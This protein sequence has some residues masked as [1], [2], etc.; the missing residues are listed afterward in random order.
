MTN[1]EK[2]T[3]YVNADQKR[4]RIFWAMMALLSEPDAQKIKDATHKDDILFG[5]VSPF[6]D[7]PQQSQDI[8]HIL[9]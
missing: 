8:P 2:L 3:A 5:Q 4:R 7:E 1:L 6:G 9:H